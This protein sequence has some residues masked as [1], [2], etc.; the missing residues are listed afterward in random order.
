M[1]SDKVKFKNKRM[2]HLMKISSFVAIT[3]IV[4]GV[5]I[6]M[7]SFGQKSLASKNEVAH[8]KFDACYVTS[9]EVVTQYGNSCLSGGT[10][11]QSNPCGE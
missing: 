6:S 11:C 4:G 1:A 5:L 3:L 10:G 7:T 9:G 8:K 2:K